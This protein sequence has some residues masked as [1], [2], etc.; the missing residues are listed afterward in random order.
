MVL[1]L[2][3]EWNNVN[4][5]NIITLTTDYLNNVPCIKYKATEHTKII[6]TQQTN[7]NGR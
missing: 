1:K 7:V 6:W 3:C 5:T 4:F 2:I